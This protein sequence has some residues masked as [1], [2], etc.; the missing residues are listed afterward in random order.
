M[1]VPLIPSC[2]SLSLILHASETGTPCL[3]LGGCCGMSY[4]MAI[5]V[6]VPNDGVSTWRDICCQVAFT[7][8]R[9]GFA[10]NARLHK[11]AR[12]R[13]QVPNTKVKEADNCEAYSLYISSSNLPNV[14]S[15]KR[16]SALP[17]VLYGEEK[18]ASA[19]CLSISSR[20]CASILA[21]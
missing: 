17:E 6:T 10:L 12:L 9:Y 4:R 3:F 21:T 8:A 11:K 1:L 19:N 5:P 7:D 18:S 2:L 14:M 20:S 16:P 13:K 15:P